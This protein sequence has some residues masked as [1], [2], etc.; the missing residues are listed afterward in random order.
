MK[1]DEELFAIADRLKKAADESD[2]V[3]KPVSDLEQAAQE[4]GRSFSGSRQGY[5]SRVYYAE[6]SPPPPGAHFSQEWGL[7]DTLHSLGSHGDWREYNNEDVENHI[8]ELAGAP[9]LED[10]HAAAE[11]MRDAH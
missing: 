11:G 2:K 7:M 5:H 8:R 10:A 1:S 6:F 3:K 4:I 9:S